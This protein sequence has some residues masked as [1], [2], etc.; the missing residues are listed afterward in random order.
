MLEFII[1]FSIEEKSST[2]CISPPFLSQGRLSSLIFPSILRKHL[3]NPCISPPFLSLGRL[4]SLIFPSLLRKHLL[5]PC[6]SPPSQGR[7]PSLISSSI[8]KIPHFLLASVLGIRNG[9]EL[10]HGAD[11]GRRP[12]GGIGRH[13]GNAERPKGPLATAL[14]LRLQSH[15]HQV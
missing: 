6:I 4:P 14:R 9:T 11:H 13:D 7:L 12:N 1:L 5:N 15:D 8:P 10:R 2:A 3:F